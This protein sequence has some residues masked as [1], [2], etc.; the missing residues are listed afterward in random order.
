MNKDDA[1][2]VNEHG[3]M[4]REEWNFPPEH[5][6]D[7]EL[8][9]CLLY[10]YMRES[11]VV[12]RIVDKIHE[13][14][15]LR[16]DARLCD[17]A[18]CGEKSRAADVLEEDIWS[19]LQL[20]HMIGPYDDGGVRTVVEDGVFPQA[21]TPWQTLPAKQKASFALWTVRHD[22]FHR[23]G[24]LALSKIRSSWDKQALELKATRDKEDK[25]LESRYGPFRKDWP[26]R[27]NAVPRASVLSRD[28][29]EDTVVRIDWRHFTNRQ[30]RDAVELWIGRNRPGSIPEPTARGKQKACD[31]RAAL[32]A[33]GVVRVCSRHTLLE[34][35]FAVPEFWEQNVAEN[36]YDGKKGRCM[37]FAEKEMRERRKLAE[38]T[39]LR[40]LPFERRCPDSWRPAGTRRRMSK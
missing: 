6:P 25:E 26:K 33:L 17:E 3:L 35:R 34:T 23:T 37:S 20:I 29:T 11:P 14:E 16:R 36:V 7:A 32:N 39:F 21:G 1:V 13:R 12:Q 15:R 4:A 28:G 31:M 22:A 2:T 38:G 19:E 18:S 9:P 10:E 30:I 40:L 5:V 27:E 24:G 8:V